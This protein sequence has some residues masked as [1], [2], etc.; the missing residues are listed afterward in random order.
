MKYSSVRMD[1]IKVRMDYS[2]TVDYSKIRMG[3]DEIWMVCGDMWYMWMEYSKSSIRQG[4]IELWY[5]N[6]E[7]RETV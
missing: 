2:S 1:Y 5:R 4:Y 3:Y 7:N 6:R